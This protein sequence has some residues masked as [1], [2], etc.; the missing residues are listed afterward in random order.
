MED[1]HI[2]YATLNKK[3][4][5]RQIRN[6]IDMGIYNQFP[7]LRNKL[8]HIEKKCYIINSEFSIN[9]QNVLTENEYVKIQK[10]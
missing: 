6:D 5:A 4:I 3:E 10:Y 7:V 8:E 2:I 9:E 1:N